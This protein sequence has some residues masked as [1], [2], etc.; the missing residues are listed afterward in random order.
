MALAP[1]TGIDAG[2]YHFTIPKVILQERGLI[3]RDDIWI[4]KFGGFYMVY[5]AGMALGGEI[6]AKLLAFGAAAAAGVLAFAGAERLRA[7]AGWM[8]AFIL[9]STPLFAGFVGYENLEPPI[10]MYLVAAAVSLFLYDGP[11]TS[12]WLLAACAFSGLAA[13]TKPNAFPVAVVLPAGAVLAILRERRGAAPVLA[14]GVVLFLITAGFWGAWNLMTTGTIVYQYPGTALDQIPSAPSSWTWVAGGVFSMLGYLCTVGTYWT[15]SAGPF[16][17]AGIAG[18]AIFLWKRCSRLPLALF[19]SSILVYIAVLAALSP[20]HLWTSFGARYVAPA[21]V[22]FGVFVAAPFAS[23]ACEQRRFFRAAVVAALLLPAVPLAFLKGGK[24]AVAAP[25]A[26]GI[27]SRSSYLAKKIETFVACETLNRLPDPNVRVLFVAY[28]PYYLD[29]PFIHAVQPESP[30]YRGLR[31]RD[32]FIRRARELAV[33]H[34]LYEPSAPQTP[35]MSDVDAFFGAPP[36]REVG[37]WP[38]WGNRW[39][40]LYELPAK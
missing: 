36:F 22:G 40:R 3:P 15:E 32:D 30:F 11:G 4:H 12:R 23:W 19:A 25:A 31:G 27:E 9:S 6:L 34:V 28:R 20:G 38:T 37:R 14:G 2:V 26:L 7:G 24:A 8:A 35:W 17:I 29:R 33:T 21:S 16:I 1:P 39:V 18:S 5:V 13:G 10:V